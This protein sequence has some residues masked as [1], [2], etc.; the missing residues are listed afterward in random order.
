MECKQ[1]VVVI[2]TLFQNDN[3]FASDEMRCLLWSSYFVVL[4][5]NSALN[6]QVRIQGG[7]PGARAPP[8]P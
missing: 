4:I 8:W 1:L 7:A 2:I 6:L 5:S 3:C